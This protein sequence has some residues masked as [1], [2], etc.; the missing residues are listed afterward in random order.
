MATI[1]QDTSLIAET[2]AV[3]CYVDFLSSYFSYVT[4]KIECIEEN[5]SDI[6]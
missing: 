1:K 6:G 2:I 5:N 4:F 3:A